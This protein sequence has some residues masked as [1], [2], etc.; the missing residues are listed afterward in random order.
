M[1]S[2]EFPE[3]TFLNVFLTL[4]SSQFTA[5][6]V[7][8]RVIRPTSEFRQVQMVKI[9]SMPFSGT[10]CILSLVFNLLRTLQTALTFGLDQTCLILNLETRILIVSQVLRL[11]TRILIVS[12]VHRQR[13]ISQILNRQEFQLMFRTG[14]LVIAWIRQ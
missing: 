4:N 6:R 2:A 1:F 5:D 3:R 8:I 12:Q 11:E 10:Q 7:I 14:K 13:H 9:P